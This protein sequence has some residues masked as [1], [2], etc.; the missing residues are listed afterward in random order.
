[1]AKYVDGFLLAVKKDRINEYKK[2]AKL[3][4]KAW[5]K[6][7]AL[8]YFEC[9]EDDLSPPMPGM[10][11]QGFVKAAKASKD[12]VVFFSF[13]VYKSKAHRD[14]VNKKVMKDPIMNTMGDPKNLPF[15]M[16]NYCVGG[17]ETVVEGK[18]RKT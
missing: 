4:A 16:K 7:G 10:K 15:N 6:H 17:F 9:K 14:Q 18:S 2:M 12:E 1:M 5:M 8:S 11:Q 3:G 13:I